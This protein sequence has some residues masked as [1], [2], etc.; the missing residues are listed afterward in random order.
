MKETQPEQGEIQPKKTESKPLDLVARSV[1]KT[2][3]SEPKSRQTSIERKPAS[4]QN[5]DS[6]VF[7]QEP[8]KEEDPK[9]NKGIQRKPV[10]VATPLVKIAVQEPQVTRKLLQK[11][12]EKKMDHQGEFPTVS[13]AKDSSLGLVELKDCVAP[14]I[15][16]KPLDEKFESDL[17]NI[18]NSFGF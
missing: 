8:V 13:I 5:S 9:P 7:V 6:A 1:P 3:V 12:Q 18:M 17:L 10:T 2:C 11:D 14:S 15:E 16:T 4:I